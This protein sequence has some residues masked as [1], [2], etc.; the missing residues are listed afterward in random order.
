M[1]TIKAVKV[2]QMRHSAAF[3]ALSV[4]YG[5]ESALRGLP[6]P[7]PQFDLYQKYEDAGIFTCLTA[8][9]GKTLIGFM[10]VVY[11]PLAHYGIQMAI[12]ESF[13]VLKAH[14]KGGAGVYL[15]QRAEQVARE[16]GSPGLLI[17]APF[18][19][20]LAK[21]L[22]RAGYGKDP[23]HLTFYKEFK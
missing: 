7:T 10:T 21:V 22:P 2:I 4:Q 3:D 11:A 9:H 8:W 18:G 1:V 17:T 12:S 13:Y 15:R 23:S 16:L 6:K 20:I 5:A 19:S 14:R